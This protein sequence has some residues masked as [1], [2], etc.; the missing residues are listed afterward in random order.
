MMLRAEPG[1]HPP[2]SHTHPDPCPHELLPLPQVYKDVSVCL[3]RKPYLC[4]GLPGPSHGLRFCPF[5]DVL[6]VGHEQGFAS[7]LVPGKGW[8]WPLGGGR[9]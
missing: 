3:T 9:G 1:P 7:L 2:P 4:H 5:E 6:G 8:Q